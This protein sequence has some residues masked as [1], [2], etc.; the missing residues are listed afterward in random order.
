ME[1]QLLSI[2]KLSSAW[3]KQGVDDFEKRLNKYVK[4]S[5]KIIP[6]IK[7]LKSN[8]KSK[9]KVEEG[10]LILS[11]IVSSDIMVLLDENGKEFSSKEFAFWIERQLI[12]GKKRLIFVIGGPYGFSDD[13]YKRGNYKIALSRMTFTHEMAKL[14]F[15]EQ[16]YRSFTILKGEPY[17]HD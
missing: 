8:E 2:G 15:S 3:I 4:F 13:V 12:S 6:D 7:S 16:I 10:K 9:I 17:H 14:F 11:E 5:S 1:I